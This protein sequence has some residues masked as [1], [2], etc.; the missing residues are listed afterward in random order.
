MTGS[1]WSILVHSEYDKY[2]SHGIDDYAT[3]RKTY[4]DEMRAENV[5]PKII[6]NDRECMEEAERYLR[7]R[8]VPQ[9]PANSV[10]ALAAQVGH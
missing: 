2:V 6:T 5:D 8:K 10:T 9:R 3:G 4:V 7:G 1:F